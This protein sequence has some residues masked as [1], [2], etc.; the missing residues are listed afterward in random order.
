ARLRAPDRITGHR[1]G[2]LAARR[3]TAA[4]A[5]GYRAA[6]N[7]ERADLGAPGQGTPSAGQYFGR[8]DDPGHDPQRPG[9]IPDPMAARWPAPGRRPV[10][11]AVDRIAV[12]ALSPRRHER[13][14]AVD[15]GR[16]L[17]TV[18][19]VPGLAFR[20]LTAGGAGDALATQHLGRATG[21]TL[22]Y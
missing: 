8:H 13:A 3:R 21:K 11:A 14:R 9:H 6:R 2:R 20:A 1:H 19:G 15:G 12:A 7:H 18:R 22:V 5:G 17:W 4:C 16:V 10:R